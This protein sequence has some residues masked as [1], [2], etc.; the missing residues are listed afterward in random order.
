V[1]RIAPAVLIASALVLASC[2]SGGSD[3]A[4]ST[5]KAAGE[6]GSTTTTVATDEAGAGHECDQGAAFD[7]VT[8]APVA[9]EDHELTMTSFDDT[10][11]RLH[12][13]PVEGASAEDPAPT[14]LMGPG[15]S[16][17]GDTD[18][19]TST[20]GAALFGSL[21][22]GSMWDAG[23]NVLT[24]D[25]R[26]FGKSGGTA[27]V[28]D[29][30]KEGQDVRAMLDF[31]AEQPEA[32]TDADGDP[33]TGMV[34]LSYG[35]GIQLT[36]ASIDCRVDAIVP[37][38]AWNSLQTSLYKADTAKTGWS[39]ILT[40]TADPKRLD[41]HINSAA[42]TG[43]TEGTVSDEDVAWFISRGPGDEGIAKIDIPTLFV[44]GTVD[45]LFTLD[46]AARNT[47]VL[48]EHDVP[49]AQLW[50]CGGH[51]TC[52]TDPGD[53]DR[54]GSASLAWLDHYLKGE[55]TDLPA[56]LDL[57]DQDGKR[58]TADAWPVPQGEPLTGT[59][60]GTL[61]LRAE[62]GSGG[63]ITPPAGDPLG[64][65]VSGITPTKAPNAVNVAIAPGDADVLA[66]GAPKLTFTYSGTFTGDAATTDGRVFAQLVDD[67]T[68]L[69]LGN[70]ITPIEVT[71]DGKDHDAEVDLE[72]VAHHVTPGHGLTLQ[73]VAA[74]TAYGIPTIKGEVT[75]A[76]IDISVPTADPD[77]VTQG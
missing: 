72:M 53:P 5:T 18:T 20:N 14:I 23:Y 15:W 43:L 38:I 25:P 7:E 17:S 51:G 31:V 26:G 61:E 3:A 49:T 21:S 40:S 67:E 41:P 69:V 29:P 76:T 34:G 27:T 12:W 60:S 4:S 22:I 28:N 45:T 11:I 77:A 48:Q 19:T 70:Q 66:L 24:W 6:K 65:L 9:G 50:F 68:G 33:R 37:G 1:R 42:E 73:I 46:E 64:S 56:A 32:L 16:L 59:G 71:L 62:G 57:I 55:D 47:A 44:Q 13:F 75:F 63:E 35:G 2:S 74:T 58:W 36:T 52:L 10:D 54:V 8:V 30:D 39:K